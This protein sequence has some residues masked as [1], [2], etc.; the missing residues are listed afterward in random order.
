VGRPFGL[1]VPQAPYHHDRL[2]E[3]LVA[4]PTETW[5]AIG[6]PFAKP[7]MAAK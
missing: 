3:E 6:L 4:A 2:I 7:A 5:R 1:A